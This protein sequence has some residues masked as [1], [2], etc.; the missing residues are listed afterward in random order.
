MLLELSI[1]NLAV[2]EAV[3]LS[4]DTGLHV[5][6]GETGA[7]KSILIDAISLVL[8]G[9]G[10]VEYVRH[11][12]NKAEITAL[13]ELAKDHSA[14]QTLSEFGLE[15]DSE[16]HV[17]IKRDI[18]R[19]GKSVCRINGHI[20][21]LTMLRQLGNSLVDIHG[22]HDHQSLLRE[23]EHVNWLDAYAGESL[24]TVKRQYREL[25]EQYR[26]L[27]ED[28]CRLNEDERQTAQRIDLLEF[29][30]N[31]ITSAS[32]KPEEDNR[33]LERRTKLTHLEKIVQHVQEAYH[34]LR[35]DN[36]AL[37]DI[38]HALSAVKAVAEYDHELEGILE[39]IQN[40]YYQLEEAQAGLG[41]LAEQQEFDQEELNDIE[42]RLHVMEQLKRKYAPSIDEI[43]QYAADVKQELDV[44][45][46]REQHTH[47]LQKQ[48]S[49]M[50]AKLTAKARE[51]S[52][53]RKEAAERLQ[54]EVERELKELYMKHARF[55]V[56]MR[57]EEGK[58]FSHGADQL[59]FLISANPGEPMKPLAKTASGG[60]LSRIMLALK[61]TFHEVDDVESLIFDEIDT[62][63]GGRAAQAIAEKMHRIA[64]GKQ[65]LCVTHLPQ[66]ACMAD[67]HIHIAKRIKSGQTMTQVR[68]LDERGRIEE[69]ARMLG[70]VEV[71]HKTKQ[72]AEEMLRLAKSKKRGMNILPPKLA[73]YR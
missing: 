32:L 73:Y 45:K 16:G 1:R 67:Q 71:T 40:A 58:F 66:V 23:E 62:G 52:A 15:T 34:A 25:Y 26:R 14:W 53:K 17:L 54:H 8:G 5:L 50:R 37:N 68:V 57:T 3:D 31:E 35:S 72:H 59:K 39:L 10:S 55:D 28:I 18:S 7:G 48:A 11:G 44:L 27:Q 19:H 22:Q 42:A 33:L 69:L 36:Q 47:D 9:R 61:T 38:G 60:E 63:V 43:L 30:L 41:R 51:L 64:K 29:Q 20:V 21:T 4:F 49:Q 13:F 24:Q 12:T 46:N 70:G 2:V 65:V 56:E 6:T